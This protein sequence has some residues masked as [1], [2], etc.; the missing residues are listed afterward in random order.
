MIFIESKQLLNCVPGEKSMNNYWHETACLLQVENWQILLATKKEKHYQ[1]ER[2]T[3]RL[4]NKVTF[5]VERCSNL[6]NCGLPYFAISPSFVL[7]IARATQIHFAQQ[8]GEQIPDNF[9]N[10]R[11]KIT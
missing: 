5:L 8:Q 10:F 3:L 9:E 7:A 1:H 2:S 6:L 4:K 11:H